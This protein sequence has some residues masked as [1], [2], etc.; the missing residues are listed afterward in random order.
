MIS[1]MVA[2][3]NGNL[4]STVA[5]RMVTGVGQWCYSGS[6]TQLRFAKALTNKS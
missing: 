6:T 1:L 3:V 2:M 4:S 5:V